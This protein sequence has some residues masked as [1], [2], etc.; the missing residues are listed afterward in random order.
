[1]APIALLA[2]VFGCQ[3]TTKGQW[4]FDPSADF[5]SYQTFAW[6]SEHPM[7]LGPSAQRQVSPLLEGRIMNA[8]GDA[9]KRNGYRQVADS[10]QADVAVAFTVGARDQIQVT[11]YP[12]NY[13]GA[14]RWGGY[15]G[16]DVDV[17]SYTEG[18]LS[19][20]VFGVEEQRPVWHGWATKR[21]S[22]KTEENPEPV[23]R[24]VVDAIL[25]NFPRGG[26]ASLGG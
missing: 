23:I 26:P 2:M 24:E 13:R 8:I 25:A 15:W 21:I 1:M 7:I 17:R 6:I 16:T 4:D 12:S 19:I 11:S 22:R 3:S 18:R 10:S 9:L 5:A 14:W 20:D